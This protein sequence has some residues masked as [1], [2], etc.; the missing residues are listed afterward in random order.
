MTEAKTDDAP[1]AKPAKKSSIATVAA[2]W[3]DD[4]R[5]PIAS[6]HSQADASAFAAAYGG[7]VEASGVAFTVTGADKDRALDDFDK[8]TR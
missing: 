1:N 7:D 8:A 3:N 2:H 4:T 6:F 5:H